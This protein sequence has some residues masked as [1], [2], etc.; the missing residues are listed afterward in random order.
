MTFN[1]ADPD[2]NGLAGATVS[3]GADVGQKGTLPVNSG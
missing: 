2:R 1:I 3:S